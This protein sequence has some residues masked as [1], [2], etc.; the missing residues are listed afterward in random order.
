[1]VHITRLSSPSL[2]VRLRWYR[3]K[4]NP[5]SSFETTDLPR[6][7]MM[8]DIGSLLTRLLRWAVKPSS[9]LPPELERLYIEMNKIQGNLRERRENNP[10]RVLKVKKE[11]TPLID[12]PGKVYEGGFSAKM[13]VEEAKRILGIQDGDL[14]EKKIQNAHRRI[15]LRNHPDRGGSQ[16]IATKINEA[17]DLLLKNQVASSTTPT[18]ENETR[19]ETPTENTTTEQGTPTEDTTTDDDE[20]EDTKKENETPTEKKEDHTRTTATSKDF[21]S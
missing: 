2:V 17:K 1:M 20:K 11:K 7:T 19:K 18:T 10:L 8:E 5:F 3:W 9:V 6:T 16:H 14:Q 12:V 21:F 4:E 15:M 13:N